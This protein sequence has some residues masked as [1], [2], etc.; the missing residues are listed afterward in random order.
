MKRFIAFFC[1]TAFSI[2]CT[3]A[4]VSKNNELTGI[5]WTNA[6]SSAQM[7]LFEKDGKYEA[8]LY[9]L[10]NKEAKDVKNPDK[11]LRDRSVNGIVIISGLT[12]KD[13]KYIGGEIYMP[14]RGATANCE[15]EKISSEQIIIV[16]SKGVIS[17]KKT[18]KK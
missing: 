16:V 14:Q 8:K 15:I 2:I 6:D 1:L 7:E 13:G 9:L 5:R 4:Q 11:K 17:K 3:Y 12:Y 18:W 10:K